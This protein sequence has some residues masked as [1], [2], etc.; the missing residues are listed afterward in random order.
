MHFYD[1]EVKGFKTTA[2]QRNS[3]FEPKSFS[4]LRKTTSLNC[5]AR[6]CLVSDNAYLLHQDVLLFVTSG[7]TPT[8]YKMQVMLGQD[9]DDKHRRFTL[10]S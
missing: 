3:F 8:R 4:A 2:Y 5:K 10:G 7:V 1:Y 6:F 9:F